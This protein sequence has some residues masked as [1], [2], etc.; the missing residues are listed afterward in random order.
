MRMLLYATRC[1]LRRLPRAGHDSG[2]PTLFTLRCRFVGVLLTCEDERLERPQ[3]HFRWCSKN[4]ER[5][6]TAAAV[7]KWPRV[8]HANRL[9]NQQRVPA[10]LSRNIAQNF[11]TVPAA[12]S[13]VPA[14]WE[15]RSRSGTST[16]EV[17]EERFGSTV[18]ISE[19]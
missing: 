18:A 15:P 2:D 11:S 10:E 1:V 6:R 16:E 12:K 13:C 8:T 14:H 19:Q 3:R 17:V 5:W 7:D 4:E 9:Q